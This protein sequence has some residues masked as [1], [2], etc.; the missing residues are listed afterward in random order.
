MWHS[1]PP[2]ILNN[3]TF[4]LVIL[5]WMKITKF[6]IE[7]RDSCA[8]DRTQFHCGNQ[9]IVDFKVM[10]INRKQLSQMIDSCY[11][12]EKCSK[13]AEACIRMMHMRVQFS[14]FLSLLA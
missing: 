7:A 4:R 1:N 12:S 5:K 14:S 13:E 8:S 6:L 9:S 10:M 2:T 11:A 3:I